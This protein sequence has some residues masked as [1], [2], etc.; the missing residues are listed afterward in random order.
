MI[1]RR[2]PGLDEESWWRCSYKDE[3]GVQCPH[4]LQDSSK[5]LPH[6]DHPECPMV[7]CLVPH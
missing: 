4:V 6:S 1:N 5:P 7:V 3:S 2:V